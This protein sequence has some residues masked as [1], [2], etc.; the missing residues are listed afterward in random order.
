[1]CLSKPIPTNIRRY[2]HLWTIYN[3]KYFN[4]NTFNPI[5]LKKN[6]SQQPKLTPKTKLTD[7]RT[8]TFDSKQ[9]GSRA[10]EADLEK[11]RST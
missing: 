1:M 5:M 3:T 11:P 6:I 2:I 4:I 8:G 7:V 10:S 9:S